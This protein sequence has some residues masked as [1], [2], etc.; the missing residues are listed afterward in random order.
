MH[1]RPAPNRRVE[2]IGRGGSPL[3]ASHVLIGRATRALAGWGV[4]SDEVQV[5]AGGRRTRPHDRVVEMVQDKRGLWKL[6][7]RMLNEMGCRSKEMDSEDC[8]A[9][10]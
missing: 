7:E 2:Q 5:V 6:R 9:Q 10:H 4:H 3:G 1:W 8:K